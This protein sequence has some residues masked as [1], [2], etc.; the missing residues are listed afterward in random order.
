MTIFAGLGPEGA[1]GDCRRRQRAAR[2]NACAAL[3][4]QDGIFSLPLLLGK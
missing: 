2:F 4:G 3:A 1:L